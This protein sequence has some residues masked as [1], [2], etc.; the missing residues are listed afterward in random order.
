MSVGEQVVRHRV[1]LLRLVRCLDK[2]VY[3]AGWGTGR[4]WT[5]W[6]KSREGATESSGSALADICGLLDSPDV[7]MLSVN[8]VAPEPS[9]LEPFL[10]RTAP[11]PICHPKIRSANGPTPCTTLTRHTYV[12]LGSNDNESRT[13]LPPYRTSS[14]TGA[15]NMGGDTGGG[16]ASADGTG[17]TRSA[18]PA[19]RGREGEREP[20]GDEA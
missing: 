7:S 2:S 6:L 14:T 15:H 8:E 1:N 5:Q 16:A 19:C 17:R 18:S 4:N 12:D 10:Y 3:E 13:L 9:L 11:V 20:G